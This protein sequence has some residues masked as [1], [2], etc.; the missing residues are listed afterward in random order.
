MHT[1]YKHTCISQNSKRQVGLT[2]ST[3]WNSKKASMRT[4]QREK[5]CT[6]LIFQVYTKYRI[7]TQ[8]ANTHTCAHCVFFCMSLPGTLA[9]TG[10]PL[11]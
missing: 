4:A 5:E 10:K 7:C 9:L 6:A 11:T 2:I 8:T 1:V 3:Y